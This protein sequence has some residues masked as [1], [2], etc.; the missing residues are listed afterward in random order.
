MSA[1]GDG[2]GAARPRPSAAR[3]HSRAGGIEAVEAFSRG[4]AFD[5]EWMGWGALRVLSRQDWAPAAVRD[6]GRVANMERLLLVL[7][8]A[9]DA[10][11]GDLGRV[12]VEAGGALWIVAGHGLAVRLANASIAARLRLVELWMRPE[13]VNAAPRVAMP[14]PAPDPGD[15]AA[16]AGATW[17]R[18]PLRGGARVSRAR[19]A[20]G[21]ALVLP[22]GDDGAHCWLEVLDGEVAATPPGLHL[23]AGDGIAWRTGDTGVPATLANP[24]RAG[25]ADV[26]FAALPA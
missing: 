12:R 13:H 22:A 15:A 20:P 3:F 11:C 6:E 1:A 19:L 26:L 24:G 23:G 10:D 9:L 14:V 16:G 5:R 7:E 25:D 4:D 2:P 18:L 8:G 21:Q 17:A